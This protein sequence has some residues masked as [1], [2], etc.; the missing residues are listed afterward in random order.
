MSTGMNMFDLEAA[1]K[2]LDDYDSVRAV[3]RPIVMHVAQADDAKSR[4]P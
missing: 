4:Q 1:F 2:F 3:M